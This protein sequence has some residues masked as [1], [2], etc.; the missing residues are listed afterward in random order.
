MI[1]DADQVANVRNRRASTFLPITLLKIVTT[2]FGSMCH[3][4]LGIEKFDRSPGIVSR[5][6]SRG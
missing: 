3:N 2:V 1:E 5:V 4:A 6:F